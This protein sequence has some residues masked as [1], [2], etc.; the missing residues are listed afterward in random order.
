MRELV[1]LK[2]LLP[3]TDRCRRVGTVLKQLSRNGYG[4]LAKV[5]IGKSPF[6]TIPRDDSAYLSSTFRY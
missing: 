3:E 5:P 6:L 2:R 1:S 4:W